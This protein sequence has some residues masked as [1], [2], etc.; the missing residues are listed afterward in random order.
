MKLKENIIRLIKTTVSKTDPN[1]ILI[2]Y[3]SYAR[4]DYND[5]S[6]I[7]LLILIDKDKIT[8]NDEK[9]MKYPLYDIEF[10]TG[11][12]ISPIVY[13]KKDWETRHRVTP[14]YENVNKEGKIL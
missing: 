12:I 6:D 7:D 5:F 2:L 14:F 8:R 13:S 3:G 10:K 11:T 9:R 1:A 4:G